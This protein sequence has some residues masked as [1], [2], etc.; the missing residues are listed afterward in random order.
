[1]FCYMLI[2]YWTS[3]SIKNALFK[4]YL[5]IY[6]LKK[7]R[8]NSLKIGWIIF[9]RLFLVMISIIV[10][11]RLCFGYRWNNKNLFN[12]FY[13]P[14]FV[15]KIVKVQQCLRMYKISHYVKRDQNKNDLQI[16][17]EAPDLRIYEWNCLTQSSKLQNAFS[18]WYVFDSRTLKQILYGTH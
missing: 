15:H 9:E 8:E 3:S 7:K 5:Y 12:Y 1:M 4:I 17:V 11:P 10:V 6:L 16:E 18:L 2:K 13:F 14:F